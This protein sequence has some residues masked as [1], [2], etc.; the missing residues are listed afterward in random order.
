[1]NEDKTKTINEYKEKFM[2]TLEKFLKELYKASK[3]E[4]LKKILTMFND[5]NVDKLVKKFY[6]KIEKHGEKITNMDDTMFTKSVT[7]LPGLNLSNVWGTLSDPHKK[8]VQIYL[9]MLFIQ[10]EIILKGT[11][12]VNTPNNDEQVVSGETSISSSNFN[13]YE[14]VGGNDEEYDTSAMYNNVEHVKPSDTPNW[15]SMAELVGLN[16]FI[17][18]DNLTEQ[19][20]NMD[21]ASI[22]D[23]VTNIKG[24]L[25]SDVNNETMGALT[26]MIGEISSELKTCNLKDGDIFN[27]LTNIASIVAEKMKPSIEKGNITVQDLWHSTKNLATQCSDNVDDNV[28][29]PINMLSNIIESHISKAENGEVYNPEFDYS[30]ILKEMGLDN[31]DTKNLDQQTLQMIKQFSSKNLR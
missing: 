20:S 4:E 22:D 8:K 18:L 15:S 14:G 5:F 19:L 26:N 25:G 9:K 10:G 12:A 23:A 1:M 3:D 6:S 2:H 16:K 27:N 28:P 17:D 11:E 13:P 31:I 29:N 7:I 30:K 24:M 21:D